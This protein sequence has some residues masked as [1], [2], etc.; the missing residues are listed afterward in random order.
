[1]RFKALS[2]FFAVL[3]FASVAY[4]FTV[5]FPSRILPK[6]MVLVDELGHVRFG[7][8]APAKVEI[9]SMPS[10][11]TGSGAGS[12]IST[13]GESDGTS[14]VTLFTVPPGK[15]LVVT[16]LDV[17]LH[18]GETILT[19]Y[20][21][22]VGPDVRFKGHFLGPDATFRHFQSGIVYEAGEAVVMESNVGVTMMGRLSPQS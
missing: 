11:D 6:G 4:A 18:A 12:A 14:P 16:D 9:T 5:T 17:A 10:C 8:A 1:M 15:T 13:F 7:T 19:L 2:A 20:S 21:N 3:G 22:V